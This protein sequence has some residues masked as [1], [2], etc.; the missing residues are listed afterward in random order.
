MLSWLMSLSTRTCALQVLREHNHFLSGKLAKAS[1]RMKEELIRIAR[2]GKHDQVETSTQKV[3]VEDISVMLETMSLENLSRY[4][5]SQTQVL[6]DAHTNLQ[7]RR[8]EGLH[9]VTAG[10]Q[11]FLSEFGRFVNAYSGIVDI[12]MLVDAQHGGVACAT[13]ALLFSVRLLSR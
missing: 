3:G 9:K 5:S 8:S 4:V 13:L 10:T 12:V 11:K 1:I 6:Q 7:E 2:T